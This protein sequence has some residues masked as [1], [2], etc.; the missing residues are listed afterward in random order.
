MEIKKDETLNE[1]FKRA[2][3]QGYSFPLAMCHGIQI[4]MK[5][6]NKS[7]V[8]VFELFVERAIIIQV[9][10]TFIYDLRG[11]K[12]LI[13]K[14]LDKCEKCG[15]YKGSV[16]EKDLNWDDSF[17][18]EKLGKSEEYLTVSCLC[19]GILCYKCKKNKIHRPISNSYDPETNRVWH[20]PYFT[21]MVGCAECRKN[22]KETAAQNLPVLYPKEM[23]RLLKMRK[24][25]EQQSEPERALHK[26]SWSPATIPPSPATRNNRETKVCFQCGQI[27]RIG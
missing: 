12:A 21:G 27:G 5:E 25:F 20:H 11:H 17:N 2:R 8:E 7:F 13:P 6:L 23:R 14:G 9:G 1:W 10:K 4:A 26:H 3:S 24:T 22:K 16:M 19:D 18:K 15:E